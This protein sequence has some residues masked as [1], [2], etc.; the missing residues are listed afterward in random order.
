MKVGIIVYS[1]TGNTLLVAQV[2]AQKLEEKGINY[3]L[4]RIETDQNK[5]M[6]AKKVVLKS[7]FDLRP[8]DCF[9]FASPIH[10]FTLAAP[11]KKFLREQFHESKKPVLGFVSQFLPFN[12]CGPNRAK[13]FLTNYLQK[14]NTP[15][16]FMGAV[17]WC[18]KNR[19][20][21]IELLV[22]GIVQELVNES[23]DSN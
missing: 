13:A 22:E 11:F 16:T 5:E 17:K 12:C 21:Q 1:Y 9:V 10:G 19:Q 7:C 2:L 23:G 15:F 20:E 3:A 18:K 6:D 14:Q 4:L 8:F